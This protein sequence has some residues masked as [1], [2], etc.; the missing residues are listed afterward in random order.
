MQRALR[1]LVQHSIDTYRNEQDATSQPHQTGVT[2]PTLFPVPP[3]QTQTPAPPHPGTPPLL[4]HPIPLVSHPQSSFPPAA[5]NGSPTAQHRNASDHLLGALL[6]VAA[7]ALKGYATTPLFREA[8]CYSQAAIFTCSSSTSFPY[9]PSRP[10]LSAPRVPRTTTADVV[11]ARRPDLSTLVLT[12]A[13]LV[14]ALEWVRTCEEGYHRICPR[15][16]SDVVESGMR[17]VRERIEDG[18]YELYNFR[19]YGALVN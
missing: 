12:T 10:S 19:S 13:R 14:T 7:P 2:T 1:D 4:P 9:R 18:M 15:E 17:G 8:L 6:L 16:V 3:I 5:A 11:T